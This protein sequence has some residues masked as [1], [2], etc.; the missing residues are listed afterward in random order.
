MTHGT[1][2]PALCFGLNVSHPF[3]FTL[4]FGLNAI[5]TQCDLDSF[6]VNHLGSIPAPAKPVS[7]VVLPAISSA[8]LRIPIEM[9]AFL[10]F[11]SIKSDRNLMP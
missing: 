5:W 2:F 3:E 11:F 1:L 10:V 8:L 4:R 9:A 7:F 6:P